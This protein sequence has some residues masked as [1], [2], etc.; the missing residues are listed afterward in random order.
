MPNGLPIA[1][2]T[3]DLQL[4]AGGGLTV[5]GTMIFFGGIRQA[6]QPVNLSTL[7]G[8]GMAVGGVWL[9]WQASRRA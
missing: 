5:G 4:I 7:L 6:S 9:L 1:I 8:G 3:R 2:P